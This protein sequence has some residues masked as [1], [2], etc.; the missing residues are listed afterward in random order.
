MDLRTLAAA[1]A[2]A[3]IERLQLSRQEKIATSVRG[4]HQAMQAAVQAAE[5]AFAPLG[6]DGA[7]E[8]QQLIAQIATRAE[9]DAQKAAQRFRDEAAAAIE[10]VA[11]ER[12][13]LRATHDTLRAEHE[14]LAAAHDTARGD[15]DAR[16][17]ELQALRTQVETLR[18][19]LEAQAGVAAALESTREGLARA[20]AEV[21]AGLQAL[22]AA[23]L[24]RERATADAVRL[25]DA[26]AQAE[27]ARLE[28]EFQLTE[29]RTRL[30]RTEALH[31]GRTG[32]EQ[33]AAE[34]AAETLDRLLAQF[35]RIAGCA[36]SSQVLTAL[37][38]ALAAEFA[39]VAL[40]SVAANRLEGMVQV[41]FELRDDASNLAI[42]LTV[43]SLLT[44]AV[45]ANA[46]ELLTEDAADGA[47]SLFGGAPGLALALPV[48]VHGEPV[49]VIYAD[50]SG[51]RA[52]AAEDERKIRIARLLLAHAMQVLERLT[53]EGGA[54][55]ELRDYATLLVAELEYTYVSDRSAGANE[56]TLRQK[57]A[58]NL[59]C[60]R[61]I[62]AQRVA[63][64]G[65]RTA[66][67][68]DEQIA[69]SIKEKE[70]EEFGRQLAAV[71][72]EGEAASP[73]TAAAAS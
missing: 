1:E 7:D 28:L 21:K 14:R 54:L 57:L 60:A 73:R 41:G 11:G 56:D 23:K 66:R 5:A 43:D 24:E 10:A 58:D 62:F 38:D 51:A 13:A 35:A 59:E 18:G 19:E 36:S 17:H 6:V 37:T 40:F 15:A 12:D 42:P 65:P 8:I 52:A 34:E 30:E 33:R 70:T 3:L 27:A 69:A 9:A 64:Q 4:L 53:N 46:V 2:S 50:D 71:A 29:T 55:A 47:R 25:E 16:A 72:G 68:L 44:R 32:D 48:P 63:G 22:E 20:E 61:R 67:L 26:R 39:R 31:A 45:A 49:A